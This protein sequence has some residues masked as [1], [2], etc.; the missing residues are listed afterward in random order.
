M[1]FQLC[2]TVNHNWVWTWPQPTPKDFTFQQLEVGILPG[3]FLNQTTGFSDITVGFS[4]L[5]NFYFWYIGIFSCSQQFLASWE[6][7]ETTKWNIFFFTNNFYYWYI[8][9][10]SCSQHFSASWEFAET[11]KWN[12]FS[13]LATFIVDIYCQTLIKRTLFV[14]GKVS[15]ISKFRF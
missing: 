9:I 15:A 12:V 11:T 10:F 5:Y 14:V 7:A 8:V 6:F 2:A 1:D 3:F 13:F 4:I